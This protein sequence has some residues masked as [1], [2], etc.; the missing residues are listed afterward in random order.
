MATKISQLP[1][2]IETNPTDFVPVV[3]NGD[4]MKVKLG[5]LYAISPTTVV[6][7]IEPSNWD[8]N[9]SYVKN[10]ITGLVKNRLF[11]MSAP[12]DA[13]LAQKE[14][15]GFAEIDAINSISD[16]AIKFTCAGA[17]PTIAIKIAITHGF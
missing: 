9:K 3:H 6:V 15:I 14:A 16:E 8:S 7:Q 12:D 13:T 10:G 5:G 4:T 1:E 17:V 11:I 2:T